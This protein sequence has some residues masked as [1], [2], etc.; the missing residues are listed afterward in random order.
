[1]PVTVPTHSLLILGLRPV[2]SI[3][4]S[5]EQKKRVD[6]SK[7][8]SDKP[9]PPKPLVCNAGACPEVYEWK[10]SLSNCSVT[11]GN[12]ECCFYTKLSLH[13]VFT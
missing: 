10:K 3:C 1:M 6:D 9:Q 4:Y 8:P 2:T 12:G 5:Q 7:C 13:H 11:C